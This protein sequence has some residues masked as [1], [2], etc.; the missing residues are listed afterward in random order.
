MHILQLLQVAED[1]EEPLVL[2]ILDIKIAM[3]RCL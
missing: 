2:T 1:D 3:C